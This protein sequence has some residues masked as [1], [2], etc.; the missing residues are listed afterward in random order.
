MSILQSTRCE[1]DAVEASGGGGGGCDV[2]MLSLSGSL[3]SSKR[4]IVALSTR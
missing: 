1:N 2:A 4:Q 3:L